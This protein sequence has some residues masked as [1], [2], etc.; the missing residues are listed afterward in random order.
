MDHTEFEATQNVSR[1]T[2][3]RLR[4]YAELLKK[5]NP[6]INL[7]SKQT[8]DALWQRHFLDSLQIYDLAENFPKSW[9]DMGVG[10][11][12]PGLV[13]GICAH[14]N[15][16]SMKLT[17]IESDQRKSAFLRTVIRE[18][19]ISAKV[20]SERIETV[21]P[22]HADVVS[23]RAL[24]DLNTLLGFSERHMARDGLSLYPKGNNWRKELEAAEKNWLFSC[25][26]TT[27]LT[28]NASVIMKIKGISR[29]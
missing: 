27:S 13:I 16:P 17:L 29:V 2:M 15:N 9:V 14:E 11:G 23:A 4:I 5:W 19:G 8:I 7:V 10:G 12:F 6:K 1:E 3:E 26:C 24:A 22:L 18:T 21:P 28:D 20:I 25:E